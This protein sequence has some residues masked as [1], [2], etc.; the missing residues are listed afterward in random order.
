MHNAYLNLEANL[1]K[2]TLQ[3]NKMQTSKKE[4]NH[5]IKGRGENMPGGQPKSFSIRFLYHSKEKL[6]GCPLD[7]ISPRP[8]CC[9]VIPT[10]RFVSYLP[11]G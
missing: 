11:V 6:F 8:L 4:E 10:L 7:T 9:D 1:P 5:N 3:L 2:L